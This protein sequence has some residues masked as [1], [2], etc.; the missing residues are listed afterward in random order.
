[1]PSTS[2][3]ETIA[4]YERE[5]TDAEFARMNA[6]FGEHTLEQGN[7]VETSER[8]G[9]VVME[10]EKFIGCASGLVYKNGADYNGLSYLT[11]LFIEKQY[12]GQGLGAMVL[13]KLE[14]KVASLG[15]TRLWTFTAGYEAPEFYK[16]QGYSVILEQEDWYATG[17]SRVALQKTLSEK[18]GSEQ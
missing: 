15:V 4:F 9:F 11:D 13:A 3:S 8:H 2:V 16:K 6:G 5:M 12:R 1:M 7:P 18:A 17:H 14:K 10:G